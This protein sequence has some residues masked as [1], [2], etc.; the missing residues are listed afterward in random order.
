MEFYGI[1]QWSPRNVG[2]TVSSSLGLPLNN[3]VAGS[4]QVEQRV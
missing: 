1:Y 3:S 2:L 4:W